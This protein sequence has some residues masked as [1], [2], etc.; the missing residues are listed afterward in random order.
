MGTK[1]VI[2]V[3][4]GIGG[5]VAALDLARAGLAVTVVER[6]ARPGGKIREVEVGDAGHRIDGGPTV[7]TLRPIFEKIFA[8]AGTTLADHLTLTPLDVLAR[9]AWNDSERL[10]LFAAIEPTVDAIAVFAGVKAAR[11]YRDFCARARQIY[12][13]LD[14]AFIQAERPSM[15]AL[16][17][18]VGLRG[19]GNFWR[20]N[21][22][23]S[24]WQ[25]LGGNFEDPR[26]RQ[27][28][29]RYA[30]YCGSSPFLAPATLML[31]AHVEQEGVWI[32]EGGM[33]RIAE[34]LAAVARALGVVFRYAEDV[35]EVIVSGA[36]TRG[37]KLAGGE[38][39]ASEAVVVNADVA[40][41]GA[42]LF[43]RSAADAVA[44]GDP[45][46]S[47]S[48]MTWAT[49]ARTENFPLLRHN[50]FFSG[51][52]AAEFDDVFRHGRMPNEPTVY[53]C[54][55]DRD[56]SGSPRVSEAERLLVLINAP[57]NGDSHRFEPSEVEQCAD[58]TFRQLERCGLRVDANAGRTVV[59]TPADFARLFPGTGGALY[60][61]ASHGWK[62]SFNRPC[63]RSRIPGLYLAGGS[64]HPGPGVPMAAVS[65]RLAAASVMADFAST[66][67]S[68]RGVTLGG[69]STH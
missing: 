15:T 16:I 33:Y 43:G 38:Q 21:P 65:G 40:A 64:T 5:L 60:G 52:Y 50:V 20:V 67:R 44:T 9:H 55:Q 31:V 30:T 46:R 35:A 23:S 62:A 34:A 36:R 13:T 1:R 17:G 24:L 59:A 7:F 22:F 53:V 26:L 6:A 61:Q 8:D 27:L 29:G 68:H 51:D 12:E 18:S 58:R 63:S 48:A 42:G 41:L 25:A 37:V 47:L 32:V 19:L 10:D 2:V 56:A 57:A 14:A 3:G 28:F 4:A 54:A 11:G 69:M 66:G 49:V 45:V 39:L